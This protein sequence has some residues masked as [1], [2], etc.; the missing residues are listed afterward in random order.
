MENPKKIIFK[1][2]NKNRRIQHACYIFLGS[3][4]TDNI[5]NI[6]EKIKEKNLYDTL[7]SISKKD[8]KILEEKYGIYWYKNFFNFYH[9]EYEFRKIIIIIVEFNGFTGE[10]LVRMILSTTLDFQIFL[11][12]RLVH[13]SM[14]Y[15]INY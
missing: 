12:T 8:V 2:K 1:F 4:V 9:L 3:L 10:L 15:F 13:Y 11:L 14:K 7:I 6:L 5:K